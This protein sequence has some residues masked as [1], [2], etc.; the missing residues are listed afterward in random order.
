MTDPL[1]DHAAGCE[2][3][4]LVAPRAARS[5]LAG[6]HDGRLKIQLAAPPVDGAANT[7]LCELLADTLDL[8]KSAIEIA[9]GQTGRRKTVRIA[10]LSAALARTR[11]GLALLLLLS[12]CTSELPFPVKVILPEETA[13][14]RRADNL[15]LQLGPNGSYSTYEV[16]GTDFAVELEL[17]PDAVVRTL[18]MYLADGTELLAWGRTAPFVLQSPP[19]DL[20]ILLARP[21]LLSTW[22]GAVPEPDADLLAA[23]GPGLGLFLLSSAGDIALLNESTY[24]VELGARLD[25]DDG[26]P[27][28]TD[29]VLVPDGAGALWRVSAADGLRAHHYDP[30]YDVWS[31]VALVGHPVGPRPGAA[32][33]PD[34]AR[35][36]LLLAGG[37]AE[38]DIVALALARD[39]DGRAEATKLFSLDAPRPGAALF[40]LHRGDVDQ[41][42]LVGG[43]TDLATVFL[44]DGARALGP[45]GPWTRPQCAALDA[46]EAD[47]VVRVL[48]LGG[49]RAGQPT[50]DALVINCPPKAEDVTVDDYPGFA[51][52]ALADPRLFADDLAVY[53]QAPTE[54]LRIA[55]DDLTV[56]QQQGPATRETGGHSITVGTGVTFLVGGRDADDRPVTNW[57]VFAPTLAPMPS[58]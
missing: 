20:A 21:G 4:V 15:A 49:L 33:A 18:S 47:N 12:A 5:R 40:A 19:T 54:W 8:P 35:E 44:P 29:G 43:D 11:L 25:P 37:G 2:L 48:C 42:L 9:R 41:L 53:A 28:A 39:D 31:P 57:W 27:A 26:L 50:P 30:A 58:P 7:A 56:T 52:L 32:W 51:P 38:P 55:R 1:R 23:R 6:V 22:P 13:D 24:A 17:E 36:R 45:A 14:L 34:A 10:G 3:D 16:R 46:V